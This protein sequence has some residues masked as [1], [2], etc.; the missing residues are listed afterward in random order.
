MNIGECL[1]Q[2]KNLNKE[3]HLILEKW[4]GLFY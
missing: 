4:K 3:F 2:Y 1:K